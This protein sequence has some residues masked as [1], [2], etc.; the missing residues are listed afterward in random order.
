MFSAQDKQHILRL[1][2]QELRIK[3]IYDEATKELLRI[4]QI[5]DIS[6]EEKPFAFADYPSLKPMAQK[7]IK[8]LGTKMLRDI[9]SEVLLSETLS[10]KK[11]SDILEKAG[12]SKRQ[13]KA[14]AEVLDRAEMLK[15]YYDTRLKDGLDISAAVWN[16]AD[17]HKAEIENAITYSLLEG[18]SA[19]DLAR[20]L[21]QHL[22]YP[23]K[24]FRRIRDEYG[25]LKL[26]KS[27]KAF[28]PGRGVY[29]SSRKN[30][31]RL[32]ATETNISYRSRD[33]ERWQE[34][35]FVV[36]IEIRLSNNHTL[37]GKPFTDIC[38]ELQGKYPKGFKFTGWHPFCRCHAV[39]ILKNEGELD[40][41]EDTP[42][43][44]EIREMP[45]VF[46]SW[47]KKNAD[48]IKRALESGKAPYFLA[49]NQL[50]L[51]KQ[52]RKD[53]LKFAKEN[54]VGKSIFYKPLNKE[55]HFTVKGM[56]EAIN[57]PHKHLFLKNE[58]L[59]NIEELI[60]NGEYLG[61]SIDTKNRDA[62]YHYINTNINKEPSTIV[63]KECRSKITFYSFTE[64]RVKNN[65]PIDSRRS[66]FT[67]RR[68]YLKAHYTAKI[69][70]NS[71]K[72]KP[73]SKEISALRHSKR[74][75]E[76]IESIKKRWAERAEKQ[77]AFN[78]VFEY[79]EKKKV[80]YKEVMPLKKELSEKDII[81]RVGGG[82]MTEGSCSSL[83][84]AYAG[85]KCGLDVLDYRGGI[86]QDVFSRSGFIKEITKGVGGLV[87]NEYNDYDAANK[88]FEFLSIGK[89]Y[90]FAIGKHAAIIRKT[91]NGVIEYLELQSHYD[92]RNTWHLLNKASLKR[93]FKV[94]TAYRKYGMKWEPPTSLIDID[95]LKNNAKI[96][97]LLGYINT[98]EA[99]QMKGA[100]GRIK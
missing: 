59:K 3:R 7:V 80:L 67:V 18:E 99:D 5:T 89:E 97:K 64:T 94:Q 23:D 76:Q 96:K 73:T 54:I 19:S 51:I 91:D 60:Q 15:N 21:K 79:I 85:N 33:F 82:D 86:S 95:L 20:N 55:I 65:E 14:S 9:D 36:G 87:I 75:P 77:K 43:E 22:L 31:L 98:N 90:Y 35:D 45:E 10:S 58:A 11:F 56:K 12:A 16:Y 41:A 70:R 78:T 69:E 50:I 47:Q 53:I 46:R 34:L 62:V 39:P 66:G 93:R 24:I 40:E 88:I 13:I 49:Q 42:S 4:A 81:S 83:A 74:S 68:G 37:N 27:A 48:R 26:S 38:D 57:Q 25:G 17:M 71:K 84:F 29:R 32:A 8:K 28:H 30:A 100:K 6:A 44:N 1:K 61:K 52:Q 63:L 2:A 72:T 92:E